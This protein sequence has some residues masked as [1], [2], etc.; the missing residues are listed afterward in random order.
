MC[1]YRSMYIKNF[2]CPK[3]N[4]IF[5]KNCSNTINNINFNSN[6]TGIIGKIE[7]AGCSGDTTSLENHIIETSGGSVSPKNIVLRT[8]GSTALFGSFFRD[9]TKTIPKGDIRG[10][11]ANDLSVSRTLCSQVASGNFS[12]ILSGT[13]NTASGELSIVVGG[14]SNISSGVNSS[15]LVGQNN[16]NSGN[17]SSILGGGFNDISGANGWIGVGNSN[18]IYGNNSSILSG[19]VNRINDGTNNSILN[20]QSNTISNNSSNSLIGSGTSNTN[21]NNNS[22]IVSGI[23]N[24]LGGTGSFNFIGSGI[25][26]SILT[27]SSNSGILTGSN[28][29]ISNPT[30]T[31]NSCILGGERNR[32]IPISGGTG[33]GINTFIGVGV[34][35]SNYNNQSVI[36]CG[37]SNTNFRTCPNSFI[38]TGESNSIDLVTVQRNNAILT[39]FRCSNF[40]TGG[41]N[42]VIVCGT[43]NQNNSSSLRNINLVGAGTF[44]RNNNL[45][46]GTVMTGFGNTNSGSNSLICNGFS[47]IVSS[48]MILSS[49][50]TGSRNSIESGTGNNVVVCG[51]DHLVVSSGHASSFIGCGTRNLNNAGN[52]SR[53]AIVTGL[54][55]NTMTG[56]NFFI[57]TGTLNRHLVG[58]ANQSSIITG[59]NNIL[60][61]N[62]SNAII[63]SGNNNTFDINAANNFLGTGNQN[64]FG[65][66]C[67]RGTIFTSLG[68]TTFGNNSFIGC[69]AS[70]FITSTASNSL[71]C[72]V[73]LTASNA[74]TAAFGQYNLDGAIGGFNR[75]FMIGIGTSPALVDR[76]NAFSVNSNG[77]VYGLEFAN[78]GADFAEYFENYHISSSKLP[79]GESVC[80]IDERFV[81][82]RINEQNEFEISSNGF[83]INDTGKIIPSFQTPNEIEPF[84][85]VV[86]NSGYVGNSFEDEW[87]GKYE[88]DE[89]RNII[90]EEQQIETYEDEYDISFNL[91]EEIKLER[92]ISENNEVSYHYVKSNILEEYNI[93]IYQEYRLYDDSNNLI[94]TINEKKKRKVIKIVKT[95]K[96]SEQFNTNLIYVPR[97]QRVEWNLIA[98]KG[99]VAVKNNQRIRSDWKRMNSINNEY[100]SYKV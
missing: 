5:E 31:I 19:N 13:N 3:I 38:G 91:R 100:T 59:S 64:T 11:G 21:T 56:N 32:I 4:L 93:P 63:V 82:K 51:E 37:I 76:R 81:G 35:N 16:I 2:Q 86:M 6:F 60:L 15:I 46:F 69:G 78:G 62:T 1:D 80:M 49:I 33:G 92:R 8:D 90:Y 71:L 66:S 9:D 7:N 40:S 18:R 36:F 30:V 39:G 20:G 95:P 17:G 10:S 48:G 28:N 73:G 58:S 53:S 34:A 14:D 57:G 23:G 24:S 94:G 77:V 52:A 22:S 45:S 97:S 50:F 61:R 72:G 83:T 47:N 43:S 42:G 55:G 84:G 54:T 88:R 89:L 74:S 99:Q 65:A 27:F 12:S 29:Q 79:I 41:V 98:L 87:Q 67:L 85:V 26:N 68:S 25:S 75:V 44:N 96:I 70:G